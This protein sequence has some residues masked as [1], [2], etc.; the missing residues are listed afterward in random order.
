MRAGTNGWSTRRLTGAEAGASTAS[1][2]L[3][4][5]ISATSSPRSAQWNILTGADPDRL[6]RPESSQGGAGPER[7]RNNDRARLERDDREDDRHEY[8]D[9]DHHAKERRGRVRGPAG[10]PS[11]SHE[12]WRAAYRARPPG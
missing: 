3:L 7:G 1:L 8:P 2:G 6:V 11:Y 9:Q 4:D 10:P 12:R 5:T